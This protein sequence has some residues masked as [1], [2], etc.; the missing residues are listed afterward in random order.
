[1]AL[2]GLRN[3]HYLEHFQASLPGNL[4]RG[5]RVYHNQWIWLLYLVEAPKTLSKKK[6]GGDYSANF[7]L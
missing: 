7:K 4:K 5:Y 2:E 6:V 1:M 3:K